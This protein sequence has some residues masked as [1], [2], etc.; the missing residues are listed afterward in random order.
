MIIIPPINIKP[1]EAGSEPPT[2]NI[3]EVDYTPVTTD[4]LKPGDAIYSDSGK[5]ATVVKVCSSGVRVY[6]DGMR[7]VIME[8]QLYHW[9]L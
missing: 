5:M 3:A 4:D 8:S 6:I 7:D 2:I 9:Y 1:I